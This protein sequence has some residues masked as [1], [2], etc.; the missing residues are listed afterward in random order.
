MHIVYGIFAIGLRLPSSSQPYRIIFV[1][2]FKQHSVNQ[3]VGTC[4]GVV[5]IIVQQICMLRKKNKF[6]VLTLEF[7]DLL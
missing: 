1:Y 4:V 2:F 3:D 7:N 5:K 6:N